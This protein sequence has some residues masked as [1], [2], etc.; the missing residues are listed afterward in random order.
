MEVPTFSK[1]P[2]HEM[3]G[4]VK[5]S[6]S[7]LEVY[8]S[9]KVTYP[10]KNQPVSWY[11]PRKWWD[12]HGDLLVYGRVKQVRTSKNHIRA[13]Q[14]RNPRIF[15]PSQLVGFLLWTSFGLAQNTMKTTSLFRSVCQPQIW[16]IKG[17]GSKLPSRHELLTMKTFA[18]YHPEYIACTTGIFGYHLQN[19]PT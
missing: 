2:F 12:C 14:P 10:Q 15:I 1:E 5:T 7:Q 17:F 11:L 13:K 9:S 19:I 18:T 8:P 3:L 16:Y 6:Y 4:P